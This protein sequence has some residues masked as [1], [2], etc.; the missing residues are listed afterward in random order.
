MKVITNEKHFRIII[1]ICVIAYFCAFFGNFFMKNNEIKAYE[2]LYA[3][4]QQS[5]KEFNSQ[6]LENNNTSNKVVEEELPLFNDAITAVDY[7]F[8]LTMGQPY[9]SKTEGMV[10]ANTMGITVNVK[11]NSTQVYFKDGSVLI[12]TMRYE[13]GSNYGQTKSSFSYYTNNNRYKKLTTNVTMDSNGKLVATYNDNYEVIE[14]YGLPKFFKVNTNTIAK[15]VYFKVNRN[16]YT[17]KI[18]SP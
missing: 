7:A 4:L 3:S 14:D 8:N 5:T 16:I 6:L 10:V 1:A 13:M 9:E 2:E 11:T 15:A 12:E 18:E 17:N